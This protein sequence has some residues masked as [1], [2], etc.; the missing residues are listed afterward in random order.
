[1]N[2]FDFF[3][4]YNIIPYLLMHK[5]LVNIIENTFKIYLGYT[6]RSSKKTDYL[7]EELAK[8]IHNYI[9]NN[10]K[11]IKYTIE[12]NISYYEKYKRCDIVFKYKN[13]CEYFFIFPVK[14]QQ[15]SFKKNKNNY[16]EQV[17]GEAVGLKINNPNAIIIP[18]NISFNE[19]PTRNNKGLIKQWEKVTKDDFKRYELVEKSKYNIIF[20]SLNLIFKVENKDKIGQK[21]E[22]VNIQSMKNIKDLLKFKYLKEKIELFIE[23]NT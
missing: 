15:T 1:M 7:H 8:F 17:I 6:S 4:M 22:N 19:I 10:N 14:F 2:I 9:F 12:K 18:I 5:K 21:Y 11:D 3:K 23:K 20:S 16:L 13:D